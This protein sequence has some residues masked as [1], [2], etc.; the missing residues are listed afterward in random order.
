MNLLNIIKKIGIILGPRM[1]L[2]LTLLI[3]GAIA[4]DYH[5]WSLKHPT[6]PAWTFLLS[7]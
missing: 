5:V 1:I 2:G 3:L 7:K 6:A 4:F